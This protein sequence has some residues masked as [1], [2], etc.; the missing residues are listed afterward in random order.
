MVTQ[1]QIIK[2]KEII[3]IAFYSWETLCST[4]HCHSPPLHIIAVILK[5][6]WEMFKLQRKWCVCLW[7]FAYSQSAVFYLTY[8]KWF[9]FQS[10]LFYCSKKTS[11]GL[12]SD[13]G[14]KLMF[15][16]SPQTEGVT[17]P[18]QMSPL[19]GGATELWSVAACD[20][21]T[22][23]SSVINFHRCFTKHRRLQVSITSQYWMGCKYWY[24]QVR[25]SRGNV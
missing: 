16:C 13:Y 7:L 11:P 6:V 17:H 18:S 20:S 3:K 4:A 14:S 24:V 8:G 19:T 12:S 22:F 23:S 21:F 15:S 9:S 2:C 25:N 10:F 5:L 1:Q